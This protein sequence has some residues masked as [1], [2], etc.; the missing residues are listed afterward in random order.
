MQLSTLTSVVVQPIGWYNLELKH[1]GS[2]VKVWV[3][4]P[5]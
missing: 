2:E 3:G 1:L 5:C 4:F